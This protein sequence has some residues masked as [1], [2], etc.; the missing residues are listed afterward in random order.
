LI[1]FDLFYRGGKIK[2]PKEN[3]K[4]TLTFKG[5]QNEAII[6]IWPCLCSDIEN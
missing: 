2:Y 1:R 3:K 5:G 6:N 4:R